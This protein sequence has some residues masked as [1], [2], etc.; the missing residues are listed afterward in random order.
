MATIT[1]TWEEFCKAFC[2]FNDAIGNTNNTQDGIGNLWKGLVLHYFGVQDI[3]DEQIERAVV[4]LNVA[5][6]GAIFRGWDLLE[7]DL[8]RTPHV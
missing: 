2:D 4:M 6:H 1:C 3:T 8:T 5:H 7:P